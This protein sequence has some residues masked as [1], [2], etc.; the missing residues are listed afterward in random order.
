MSGR[1]WK[2][3]WENRR[4]D[5]SRG[6]ALARLMCADGLDTKFGA[7]SEN[8]WRS[9]VR[10][11]A[12]AAGIS[13]GCTIFEVGCGAGAWIYDFYERGYTVAGLDR[14]P[15]LVEHTRLVM[16]GGNW[17]CAD[18]LDVDPVPPYDF[19]VACG[20]FTYFDSLEYAAAVLRKMAAKA[21]RGVMILD[22]PDLAK[23]AAAIDFRRGTLGEEQ[24]RELYSGL[25]HA[26]YDKQWF[27]RVLA[28]AGLSRI[29]I[30]D[31]A[32]EGYANSAFRY[33]VIASRC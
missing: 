2:Q 32:I 10:A 17:T 14:S 21:V 30:E 20:V 8:A 9:F 28:E 25:D 5:E 22:V 1:T 29:A 4:I 13:P 24:Y 23:R 33:N 27:L 26:Y 3:V 16:P 19:V 7:V 11:I 6:S 31:Q 15:V 18:A 12:D